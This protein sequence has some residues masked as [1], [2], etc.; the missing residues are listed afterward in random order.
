MNN[1][2]DR[3]RLV[4]CRQPHVGV[5]Y[6]STESERDEESACVVCV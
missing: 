6:S 1:I 5:S 2:S 4:V 3:H